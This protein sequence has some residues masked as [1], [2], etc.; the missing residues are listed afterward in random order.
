M[1]VYPAAGENTAECKRAHDTIR[2]RVS[3][4]VRTVPELICGQMRHHSCQDSGYQRVPPTQHCGD[5]KERHPLP[6]MQNDIYAGK[7]SVVK[8]L[9]KLPQGAGDAEH[10]EIVQQVVKVDKDAGEKRRC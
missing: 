3:Q 10:D 1:L 2:D 9:K 4:G 6:C 8:R 7:V 5:S